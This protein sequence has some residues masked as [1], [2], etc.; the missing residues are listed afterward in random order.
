MNKAMIKASKD[1]QDV[2]SE[3]PLDFAAWAGLSAKLL[4]RDRDTRLDI[5]EEHKIEV[6]TW[7]A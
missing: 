4:Q 1:V 6:E 5:L 2:E 3:P 7:N